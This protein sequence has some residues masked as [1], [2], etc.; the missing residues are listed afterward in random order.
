MFFLQLFYP[1]W[2]D[3][4]ILYISYL[5]CCE[6]CIYNTIVHHWENIAGILRYISSLLVSTTQEIQLTLLVLCQISVYLVVSCVA[7][8][9]F[10][11]YALILSVINATQAVGSMLWYKGLTEQQIGQSG[12]WY[13]IC[14]LIRIISYYGY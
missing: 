7:R 8:E 5:L 14:T 9:S 10:Y 3:L 13:N 6:Y 11:Y 2:N 4:F 1:W 12:I